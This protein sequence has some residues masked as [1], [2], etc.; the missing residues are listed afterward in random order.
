MSSS[1]PTLDTVLM[2]IRLMEEVLLFVSA[3]SCVCFS[4]VGCEFSMSLQEV[5]IVGEVHNRNFSQ[6]TE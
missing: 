1:S 4:L 6:H 2:L 5:K 3:I